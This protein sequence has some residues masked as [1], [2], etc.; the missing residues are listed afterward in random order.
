MKETAGRLESALKEKG[1]NVIARVN[2]AQAAKKAEMD[3]RATEVVIFG[4][5]KTGTPLMQCA[6]TIGIDLPQK[7]LVWEDE[8]GQVWL[9]YNDQQYLAKRHGIARCDAAVSAMSGALANFAKRRPTGNASSKSR[10]SIL[11]PVLGEKFSIDAVFPPETRFP[12]PAK[13]APKC[14]RVSAAQIQNTEIVFSRT[15]LPQVAFAY[16][17][18]KIVHEHRRL[19]HAM[20]PE[21]WQFAS[22]KSDAVS[23]AEDV[24]RGNRTQ[25]RIHAQPFLLVARQPKLASERVRFEPRRKH[26]HVELVTSALLRVCRIARNAF[27]FF[28]ACDADTA[29]FEAAGHPA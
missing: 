26:E 7:A 24:V 1:V 4:N 27:D 2:H 14:K 5:A 25:A 12:K 17:C 10:A 19:P 20:H 18:E 9:A 23:H 8:K 11:N 22:V 13:R 29:A 3:L 21:H 15:I 16:A 6:Q 28:V